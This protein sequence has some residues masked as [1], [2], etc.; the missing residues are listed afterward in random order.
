LRGIKGLAEVL[1]KKNL[2]RK[3]D[4]IPGE[5]KSRKQFLTEE[6]RFLGYKRKED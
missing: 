1:T 6:E 5:G 3:E 2:L 4:I